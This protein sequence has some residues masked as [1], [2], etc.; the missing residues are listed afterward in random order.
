MAVAE[1][2]AISTVVNATTVL[3]AQ[4]IA[5]LKTPIRDG[6]AGVAATGSDWALSTHQSAEQRHPQSHCISQKC[7]SNACL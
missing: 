2:V 3:S 6:Q 1:L 7:F 5:L 4:A